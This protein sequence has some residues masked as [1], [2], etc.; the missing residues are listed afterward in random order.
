MVKTCSRQSAPGT[1]QTVFQSLL[2]RTALLSLLFAS[3]GYAEEPWVWISTDGTKKLKAFD[4]SNSQ[5]RP[6]DQ[7]WL[8]LNHPPGEDGRTEAI[9]N[10]HAVFDTL[11]LGTS[12]HGAGYEVVVHFTREK[13]GTP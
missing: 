9:P 11:L 13:I 8:D 2:D 6:A 1:L 7:H 10:P 12:R 5:G 4:I 3:S